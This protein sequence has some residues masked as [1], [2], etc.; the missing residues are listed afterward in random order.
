M[1]ELKHAISNSFGQLSSADIDEMLSYFHHEQ[2]DKNDFFVREGSYCNRLSYQVSGILRVYKIVGDK[3]ITQW[4]SSPGYFV[5][6]LSS[7]FFDQS[8]RWSIQALSDVQLL[9]ISKENYHKISRDLPQWNTTEKYFIA[10]CFATLENRV[11]EHLSLTAEERYDSYFSQN[12]ELFNQV[13]LQYI[14]SVL[15][16]SAE[17]LSRIRKRKLDFS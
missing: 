1:N 10:Q 11:F 9:S 16:M 15:G 12:K 8:S 14:A 3:E 2:L 7:F 13:P 17:T 5:T 6:E 4:I